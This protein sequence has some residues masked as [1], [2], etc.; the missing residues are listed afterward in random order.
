MSARRRGRLLRQPHGFEGLV[1][2]GESAPAHYLAVAEGVDQRVRRKLGDDAGVPPPLAL[3]A[4]QSHH[5]IAR[6][7]Y[8]P[9]VELDVSPSL[10]PPSPIGANALVAEIDVRQIGDQVPRSR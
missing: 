8:V 7:Q 6:V 2:L 3:I 10:I 9:K 1:L 4:D 5:L